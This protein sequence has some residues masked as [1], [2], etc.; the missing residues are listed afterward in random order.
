MIVS[1]SLAA[2]TGEA[3]PDD[4]YRIVYLDKVVARR[5]VENRADA[6]D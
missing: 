6:V 3:I 5:C 2:T 1:R 4:R